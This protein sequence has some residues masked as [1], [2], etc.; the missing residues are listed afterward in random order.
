MFVLKLSG[1]QKILYSFNTPCRYICTNIHNLK[2]CFKVLTLFDL[3]IHS[4]QI[5]RLIDNRHMQMDKQRQIYRWIHRY[6]ERWIHR[7]VDRWI[8]RQ[9]YRWL[10]K[11]IY[12][13]IDISQIN[14]YMFISQINGYIDRWIHKKMFKQIDKYLD[15]KVVRYLDTQID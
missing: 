4:R 5:D 11:Q 6:V 15:R 10:H 7:Y 2:C 13:W 14:K 1:I 3:Q 12:R 9:I 8:H